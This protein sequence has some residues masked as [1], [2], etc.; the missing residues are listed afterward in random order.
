MSNGATNR[1]GN[2]ILRPDLGEEERT[3]LPH[4]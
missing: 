2:L 3:M 1:F 4:R